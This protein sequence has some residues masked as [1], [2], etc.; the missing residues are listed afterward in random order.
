MT[1]QD[2]IALPMATDAASL[3]EQANTQWQTGDWPSLAAL[4]RD[5]LQHHPDRAKLAL[6]AA[7]G[8]LQTDKADEARQYICLA[9]DWGVNK[10]LLTRILAAGVHN[11]LGRAAAIAGEH[12]RALQHLH[13]AIATG[14]PGSK[15]R[16]PVQ[17]RISHQYRQLGLTPVA[18]CHIPGDHSSHHSSHKLKT[19]VLLSNYV[20]EPAPL[21]SIPKLLVDESKSQNKI[22]DN[23]Q[24]RTLVPEDLLIFQKNESLQSKKHSQRVGKRELLAEYFNLINFVAAIINKIENVNK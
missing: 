6:L 5:S 11:S 7:A 21:F 13:S 20:N 1:H 3:L 23:N 22:D 10:T 17:A 8:R 12:S 18:T 19:S 15:A 24:N 2:P 14:S 4:Q 9:K 16:L